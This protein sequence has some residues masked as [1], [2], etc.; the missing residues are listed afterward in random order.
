MFAAILG[1]PEEAG[2]RA[3]VTGTAQALFLVTPA[4][5]ESAFQPH[6]EVISCWTVCR[7]HRILSSLDI[8]PLW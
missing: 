7:A 6:P 5:G 2:V 1:R 8:C 3:C 4:Q